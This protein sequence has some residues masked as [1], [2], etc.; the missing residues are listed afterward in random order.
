MEFISKVVFC[1]GEEATAEEES[2]LLRDLGLWWKSMV[3]ASLLQH[4][5]ALCAAVKDLGAKL[6]GN[7]QQLRSRIKSGLT[8]E[9]CGVRT[10]LC[11][12]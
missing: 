2:D 7:K 8:E 12:V 5:A 9:V 11:G 3:D 4:P 10:L 6:K 1:F